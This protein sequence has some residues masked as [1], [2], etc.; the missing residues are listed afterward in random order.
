MKRVQH[1]IIRIQEED[2]KLCTEKC[3]ERDPFEDKEV[4]EVENRKDLGVCKQG[5]AEGQ[6][7]DETNSALQK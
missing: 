2:R 3:K 4:E 6:A 7:G 1:F 5:G